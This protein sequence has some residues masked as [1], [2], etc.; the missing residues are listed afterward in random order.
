MVSR[1]KSRYKCTVSF[2]PWRLT[3]PMAWRSKLRAALGLSASMGCTKTKWWEHTKFMPAGLRSKDSSRSRLSNP[4]A[5]NWRMTRRR[6]KTEPC[7]VRH[8]MPTSS[9]ATFIFL[10]STSN[11]TK[12]ITFASCSLLQIF[13]SWPQTASNLEPKRDT[14]LLSAS[15]D[16]L[17]TSLA[18]ATLLICSAR[19]QVGHLP[20]VFNQLPMQSWQKMWPQEVTLQSSGSIA[21]MQ[22]GQS[23]VSCS[24]F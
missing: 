20:L 14:R 11:W 15:W 19:L 13:R 2:C 1:T 24:S 7:K 5:W 4:W 17:S 21:V 8:G 10:S 22:M 12:M 3:R 23:T 16:L 18:K 6:S 9:R